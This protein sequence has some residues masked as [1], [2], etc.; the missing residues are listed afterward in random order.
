MTLRTRTA[1]LVLAAIFAAA[2]A[3]AIAAMGCASC[4]CPPAPCQWTPGDCAVTLA[5]APCCGE[6]PT[7]VPS[8]ATRT[9]EAPT[10]HATLPTRL[11]AIAPDCRP[12]TVVRRGDLEARVSPLRLSVVLLI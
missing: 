10:F 4:C 7:A 8:A 6:A 1:A 11:S 5:D 9:H 3:L 12:G 2:P